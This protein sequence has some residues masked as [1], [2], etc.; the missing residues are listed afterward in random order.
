ML[1]TAVRGACPAPLPGRAA[2]TSVVLTAAILGAVL[3]CPRN[4]A[5]NQRSL[6]THHSFPDIILNSRFT[7][8][9]SDQI[10][11]KRLIVHAFEPK[12]PSP[13]RGD[14]GSRIAGGM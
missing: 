2:G 11:G 12:S 9:R 8:L 4:Y 3:L 5:L 10:A 7:P 1:L 13:G 6:H 14:L